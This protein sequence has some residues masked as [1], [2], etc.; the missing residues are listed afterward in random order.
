MPECSRIDPLVTPF[1]DGEL[2]PGEQL[3]VIQHIEACPPCR[4]R[5]AAERAIRSLMT[6]CRPELNATPAPA[7][8]KH[9]CALLKSRPPATLEPFRPA[10]TISSGRSLWRTRLAPFALAA[11][12]VLAIGTAF[13]YQATRS[14]SRLLAAELALDHQKCFRLNALLGT[15]D[16]VDTVQASMSSWFNWNVQLPDIAAH[17]NIALVGSRPCLYG[18][19]KV[20]HIMYRHNG[21]PV[22]LFMLPRTARQDQLVQVFGHQCRIWSEG[23]RT[24][25]LVARESPSEM[26]RLATLVRTTVR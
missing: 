6:R 24:F 26:E 25:V 19:G 8:L 21:Q 16:T 22:S 9:R 4:A 13:L 20:A 3:T 5:V 18:E 1:V 23:D 15:Q 11:A 7:E 14:S 10:R 2:P 17:Q 12:L